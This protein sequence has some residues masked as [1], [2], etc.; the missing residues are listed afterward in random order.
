MYFL[1]WWFLISFCLVN[2]Y[3]LL[4]RSDSDLNFF[5]LTTRQL[6]QFLSTTLSLREVRGSIPVP[7]KSDTV[8][9]TARQSSPLRRFFGA[10]LPGAKPRR[11]APP[12]VTRFGV[13]PQVY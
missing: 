13:M 11:W 4:A 5:L 9:P 7:I 12:L 8:P 1:F 6:A 2:L 3:P 10:V